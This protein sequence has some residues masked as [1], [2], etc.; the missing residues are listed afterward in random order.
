MAIYGDLGLNVQQNIIIDK[1]YKTLKD[2]NDANNPDD[3]KDDGIFVGRFVQINNGTS[4]VADDNLTVWRKVSYGK[5]ELFANY[6]VKLPTIE[7]AAQASQMGTNPTIQFNSDTEHYVL[8]LPQMSSLIQNV[9][10]SYSDGNTNKAELVR[11]VSSTNNIVNYQLKLQIDAIGKTLAAFN[12]YF[13]NNGLTIQA[14]NNFIS[15]YNALVS[16]YE[17]YFQNPPSSSNKGLTIQAYNDF[18]E[19]YNMLV[20]DYNEYFNANTG[21][22]PVKYKELTDDHSEYFG[23]NGKVPIKYKELT[24][25][26]NEYFG[27]NGKV[28]S[29]DNW[30]E[31]PTDVESSVVV[32]VEGDKKYLLFPYQE[33]GQIWKAAKINLNEVLSLMKAT[34]SI[35]ENTKSLV[36][37]LQA[38]NE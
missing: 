34:M 19:K 28:S 31:K 33:N 17:K 10:F 7:L 12:N 24:D 6:N 5:Y 3:N 21:Y 9:D 2:L 32:H 15:R 27:E 37:S 35:E 26:Y 16:D 36:F 30:S 1:T 13:G 11:H 23:E 14:Y 18:I 22:V 29:F 38:E 20:G 4:N 8:T 25:D